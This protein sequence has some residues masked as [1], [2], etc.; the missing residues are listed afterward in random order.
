MA[1]PQQD[2]QKV[3]AEYGFVR[4]NWTKLSLIIVASALIGIAIGHFL[5]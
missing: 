4:Q 1:D 2:L 5:L 3:E